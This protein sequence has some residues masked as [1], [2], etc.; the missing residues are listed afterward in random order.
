MKWYHSVIMVG[1]LMAC[2]C[3]CDSPQE[4]VVKKV[5]RDYEIAKKGGDPTE[6]YTDAC[7]VAEAYKQ[8][9]DEANYLKWKEISERHKKEHEEHIKNQIYNTNYR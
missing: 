1:V 9:G 3:G 5:I 2:G 6:I 4:Q 7:L 8:A